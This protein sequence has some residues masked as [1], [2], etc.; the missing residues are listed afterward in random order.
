MFLHRLLVLLILTA[1]AV[2]AYST[3]TVATS[4][5]YVYPTATA[6]STP[7]PTPTKGTTSSGCVGF[8]CGSTSCLP[9]TTKLI[10]YLCNDRC[11]GK[12]T[13]TSTVITY[14]PP[15]TATV[16]CGIKYQKR[17][18]EEPDLE[19]RWTCAPGPTI[20]T[21]TNLPCTA[22]KAYPHSTTVTSSVVSTTT[23]FETCLSAT[24]T[25]TPSF[26]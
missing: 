1:T 9:S 17:L 6:P 23:L 24:P 12:S 18:G 25:P 10:H 19:K 22:C 20:T 2:S 8:A 15:V 11:L 13:S 3:V 5:T 14:P 7:T 4:T 26:K 21:S 16:P